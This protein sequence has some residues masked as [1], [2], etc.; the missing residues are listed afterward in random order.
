MDDINL[1]EFE[2]LNGE[3]HVIAIECNISDRKFIITN[4]RK[5]FEMIDGKYKE[6][7]QDDE[8]T[9]FL[10][11]YTAPARATDIEIDEAR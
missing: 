4:G 9:A 3:K 2:D 11:K 6:S 10:K 5:I 8:E 7:T 1:K